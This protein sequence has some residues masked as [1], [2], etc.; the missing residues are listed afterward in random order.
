MRVV[1]P[2]NVREKV[3]VQ[4]W[5]LNQEHSKLLDH[6]LNPRL[7]EAPPELSDRDYQVAETVVQWLGSP[8][9]KLFLEDCEK[10]ALLNGG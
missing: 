6:L 3:F 4:R 10:E 2:H 5:R 7:E 9:G 1:Q 8:I